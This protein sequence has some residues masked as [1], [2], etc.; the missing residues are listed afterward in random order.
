MVCGLCCAT[1]CSASESPPPSDPSL[2]HLEEVR[3]GFDNNIQLQEFNLLSL[4]VHNVSSNPWN[5]PLRLTQV[6][7]GRQPLGIPLQLDV[8]LGPEESRWVQFTVMLNDSL[9]GWFL[10]WGG[11][12]FGT[13]ELQTPAAGPRPTVLIYNPDTVLS[14]T[15]PLRRMPEELFPQN[16]A[17][18][19][20]LRGVIFHTV[21]FWTGARVR[22]LREWLNGGGRVYLLKTSQGSYPRFPSG[23]DFLN[24]ESNEYS[25]GAGVVKRLPFT[26]E[27]LDI[28]AARNLLFNDDRPS[29]SATGRSTMLNQYG[30]M[31]PTE[32]VGWQRHE[33]ASRELRKLAIFKRPWLLIYL[34]VACYLVTL[35]P[36]CYRL[37]QD[38]AE[39]RWFYITFFGSVLIFSALFVGLG[40][41][42]GH[43]F[44]RL[45]SLG[46]ARELEEGV[47][48]VTQWT[49]ACARSDGTYHLTLAGNGAAV[50]GL[51]DLEAFPGSYD[52]S[53]NELTM[54]MA[55]ASTLGLY[56]RNRVTS[57]LQRP[58]LANFEQTANAVQSA[59]VSPGPDFD[60]SAIAAW[61]VHRDVAYPLDISE[62]V[63][64][65]SRQ[66]RSMGIS[67][68]ITPAD[69][70]SIGPLGMWRT[71]APA[72]SDIPEAE[73]VILERIRPLLIAAAFQQSAAVDERRCRV[74]E[75]QV[76]LLIQRSLPDDFKVPSSDFPDQR[77]TLLFAFDYPTGSESLR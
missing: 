18:T 71:S 28:D 61:L 3:W 2:L 58:H 70:Q 41:V 43:E 60:K 5:G 76:R 36:V 74:P 56:Q 22:T 64:K 47:F 72:E 38:H 39:V 24:Q 7:P 10:D 54:D 62:A 49:M 42:G 44:N 63:W 21:P 26:L 34:A 29:I 37:G 35:F 1:I 46:A 33:W 15:S 68:I 75:G 4:K 67:G 51:N 50:H 9:E 59:Q 52:C 17:G 77:G 14:T 31:P 30:Y 23:M 32:A 53:T 69:Q 25:V 40:Q 27:D 65:L 13:L 11:G 6:L 73:Q 16:L 66:H 19:A 45:R 20:S 55:P 48:D 12:E 57:S 8:A